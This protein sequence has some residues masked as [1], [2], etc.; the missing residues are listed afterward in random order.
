MTEPRAADDF[1]AIRSRLLDITTQRTYARKRCPHCDEAMT[2]QH[3]PGCQFTGPVV[4][5]EV[6]PAEPQL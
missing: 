5:S 2:S 3:A 1:D 4:E 6:R